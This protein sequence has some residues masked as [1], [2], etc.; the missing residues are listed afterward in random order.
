MV[1]QRH[2]IREWLTVIEDFEAVK[3]PIDIEKFPASKY[4]LT[5][6]IP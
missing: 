1:L 5:N 4:R 3:S 2:E 6:P